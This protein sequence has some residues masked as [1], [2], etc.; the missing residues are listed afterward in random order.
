MTKQIRIESYKD[1][2]LYYLTQHVHPTC[3]MLHTIGTTLGLL[4]LIALIVTGKWWFFLLG[5]ALGYGFAWT[6][7]FFFEKNKPAAF[8]KPWWSFISDWVMLKDVFTGS[9]QAKLQQAISKYGEYVSDEA[10][11]AAGIK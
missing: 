9:I 5:L 7:H 10:K 3:R 8:S 2:Y 4:C 6:G 1:F 11:A